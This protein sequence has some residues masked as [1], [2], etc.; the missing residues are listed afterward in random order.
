MGPILKQVREPRSERQVHDGTRIH[1]YKPEARPTVMVRTQS[2]FSVVHGPLIYDR[3]VKHQGDV[4]GLKRPSESR[5]MVEC[6]S[7]TVSSFDLTP[8]FPGLFKARNHR[9]A[10]VR[11]YSIFEWTMLTPSRL[12]WCV[13]LCVHPQKCLLID[14]LVVSVSSRL[15]QHGYPSYTYT[16]SLP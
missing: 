8:R 15:P 1:G 2:C 16:C 13:S 7:G 5:S 12:P 14:L 6:V 3:S 9:T 10:R 4:R 11:R